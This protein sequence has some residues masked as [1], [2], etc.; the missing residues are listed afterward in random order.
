MRAPDYEALDKSGL[1]Y[2]R[3]AKQISEL[4]LEM[5]SAALESATMEI[6]RRLGLNAI[7]QISFGVPVHVAFGMTRPQAK[8]HEAH[9]LLL[10]AGGDLDLTTCPM[11][12]SP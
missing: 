6:S 7:R 8:N 9:G 10:T 4:P 5:R 12:E 3:A 2:I 11:F 1:P